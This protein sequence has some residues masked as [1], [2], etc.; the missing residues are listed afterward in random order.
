LAGSIRYFSCDAGVPEQV[1]AA[2]KAAGPRDILINNVATQPEA[3]C[4]EHSLEDWMRA[5]NVNLTSYFLF[6]KFC[7]PHM[8]KAGK[9]V[10]V[11]MASVQGLQSQPGI[12]G[13][14]ASKGGVLS[15]TRQLA[16]EYAD[17]GIR[18]T[19]INPG[20]INTPLVSRILKLRGTTKAQAGAVYP[21]RRIGEIQEISN[22]VLFLASDEASFITAE[23]LTVDGGIMGLGGWAQ[24]A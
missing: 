18:V 7:L 21:M 10:I 2:S 23:S 15:L 9:G 22:A 5:L 16:M 17:K 3:P 11:N 13:Y 4:H 24:V 12:P 14:A 19:A 1:E 6:S 20:T 8:L